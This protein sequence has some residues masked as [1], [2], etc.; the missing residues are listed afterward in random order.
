L[1]EEEYAAGVVRAE[2]KWLRSMIAD[3]RS[4]ALA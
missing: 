3:L 2:L 4:G 1:L